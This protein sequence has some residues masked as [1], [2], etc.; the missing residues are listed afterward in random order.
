MRKDVWRLRPD[1]RVKFQV[2]FG[3]F[4]GSYV[5]HCHNTVH[6]DFAMLVRYQ[7]LSPPPGDPDYAKT[8]SS[9]HYKPTM[10]PLPSASGVT[11]KQPE[12]LPEADPVNSRFFT[13]A[14]SKT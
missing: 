9:P 2:R 1:G 8:G 3:E 12:V 10:T 6:E 11:W 5:S 14:V 13:G 4:G 7:L